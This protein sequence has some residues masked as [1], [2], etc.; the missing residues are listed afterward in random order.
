MPRSDELPIIQPSPFDRTSNEGSGIS[1][2]D[3]CGVLHCAIPLFI[4]GQCCG[5]NI[6]MSRRP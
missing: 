5:M 2:E 1:F 3:R 6:V 4:I